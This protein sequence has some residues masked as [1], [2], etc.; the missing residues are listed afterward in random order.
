MGLLILLLNLS[1]PLFSLSVYIYKKSI[2]QFLCWKTQDAALMCGKRLKRELSSKAFGIFLLVDKSRSKSVCGSFYAACNSVLR[3]FMFSSLIV[4]KTSGEIMKWRHKE[5][6]YCTCSYILL[7]AYYIFYIYHKVTIIFE[8]CSFSTSMK[9]G[10]CG[11]TS[12]HFASSLTL[13]Y[14]IFSCI[15]IKRIAL[16]KFIISWTSTS[17]GRREDQPW[18]SSPVRPVW[19]CLVLW[20]SQTTL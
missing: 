9:N 15:S 16:V 1:L 6:F 11:G 13:F 20:M 4:P 17:P 18:W 14:F 7:L 8:N 5:L 2:V 19:T 3:L 10:Q 12:Q